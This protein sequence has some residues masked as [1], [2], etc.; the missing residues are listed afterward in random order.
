MNDTGKTGKAEQTEQN[1][2]L[3]F[4][5]SEQQLLSGAAG[6][7]AKAL[8]QLRQAN[9]GEIPPFV[10][11]LPS[12]YTQSAQATSAPTTSEPEPSAELMHTLKQTLQAAHITEPFAVRSSALDEDGTEHS[13]AGQLSS[14][15]DV[16]AADLADKI[17]AV[18]Q[19]GL[20]GAVVAYRK[21][22]GLDQEGDHAEPPAVI[23]MSMLQPKT[24]GV[25]FSAHPVSGD[26]ETVVI[27]AVA[28]LAEKLVSG[29]ETGQSY[30]V[31][32]VG[33]ATGSDGADQL[34]SAEEQQ[35]IAELARTCEKHFGR[36]QDIE[37][38]IT[39]EP[40]RPQSW[41]LWLLQ[42]RPITTLKPDFSSPD[43]ATVWWDNSN[44]IESYSGVTTPLTF[45]FARRA[46]AAV[47]RRFLA[48]LGV[49]DA[50]I[51]RNGSVLDGMIG[52]YRGRIYY[53]L[54]HW[55]QML[56]LLPGFS[57]NRR[58]METMM[59]VAEGMPA[60][61]K[62]Q[63]SRS[64]TEDAVHFARTI[65]GLI[66]AHQRL[67]HTRDAF[68]E[69]LTRVLRTPEP[70]LEQRSLAGLVKHYRE[71]E[72]SLLY[73][74]DAPLINDF[75]A[76]IHYGVLKTLCIKWLD[77]ESGSLQ[78]DLITA[79]GGMVSA[80]PAERIA[81]L[82]RLAPPELQPLLATGTL[83]EIERVVSEGSQEVWAAAQAYLAKFGERT[84][85]ELKLESTTLL[86]DPLPLWRAVARQMQH[87][88]PEH[89]G[90]QKR[91]NAEQIA[92]E[93]L[94]PHQQVIFR[95]VLKN[96]REKVRDRENLRLERTR[97]FGRSRSIL[98]ECGKRLHE[99]GALDTPEQVFYLE[100]EEILGF[101]EGGTNTLGLSELAR[102][103]EREFAVYRKEANPPRRFST[104]GGLHL[105]NIPPAQ[106]SQPNVDA[107]LGPDCRKGIGCSPGQISG[108]VRVVRDPS[109]VQLDEPIIMVAE[110]TDPGWILILPMARA[111]LVERGSMLSHSA[112]V[113]R[114]LGIPAIV[115]VDHLMDWLQDGDYVEMDGQSGLIR[116]ISKAEYEQKEQKP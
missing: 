69:R 42:S 82:A 116:R 50:D 38:A 5:A 40:T 35:A 2:P 41:R 76:M 88:S 70:P 62:V 61:L 89:G 98:R 91:D 9:I 77:D 20:S 108:P 71:L 106:S 47:Y 114:E 23:I 65:A 100:V 105:A 60:D 39:T 74:W 79:T 75:M 24:A 7:K 97:V 110:R 34:L 13:F 14:Y 99:A 36:P 111:L 8:A 18:W 101:V 52:L 112:I 25:A 80:E 86:D 81:E 12:A 43:D 73:C 45:S 90:A 59:G 58:F 49:A 72:S 87:S 10:A 46:Y 21:E 78:N 37:W 63:S 85:D 44:I 54:N 57:F 11:L 96:A 68:L 94:K 55:Y 104:R 95:W 31:G 28:G 115:A 56:S 103:R 53:N 92:L 67:P 84:N 51:I 93:R 22:R 26:R 48:L 32:Q 107:E 102:L 4:I 19:S 83:A 1:R 33:Q 30:Q 6:G 66:W 113:S 3:A 27:N 16:S 17:A 64:P 109:N 15:L 29:E